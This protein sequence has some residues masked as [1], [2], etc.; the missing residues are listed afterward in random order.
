FGFERFDAAGRYREQENGQPVDG[1]GL[2][3]DVEGLGSGTE[4][5][6]QE[7]RGLADALVAADSARACFARQYYRF[8]SGALEQSQDACAIA[9]VEQR[10][11]EAGYDIRELII[12]IIRSPGFTQRQ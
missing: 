5:Q 1:A 11:A 2:L 3:N 6:F 4:V 7:L 8:A 9:A 10:W 12:A